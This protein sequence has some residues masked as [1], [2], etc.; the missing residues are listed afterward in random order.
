MMVAK[1]VLWQGAILVFAWCLS[2][3]AM[4]A[5]AQGRRALPPEAESGGVSPGE[6]QRLFD[7]YVLVQAQETLRLDDAQFAK[8]LPRLRTLQ[9]VRRRSQTER[10]RIVQDLRQLVQREGESGAI[11]DRLKGLRDF[12][13][14]T[15][16]EMR[17]AADDLD[18]VLEPVQRARLRIFQE[19][20]ERRQLELLLRARQGARARNRR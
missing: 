17:R 10:A 19:Q 5:G 1:Y 7:A 4:H 9:D 8:F 2:F 16:D 13:A 14:R 6:L 3:G 20:M 12:E 15:V 11:T 18:E